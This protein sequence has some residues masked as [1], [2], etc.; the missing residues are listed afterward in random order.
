MQSI[1]VNAT[2]SVNATILVLFP[3]N[4]CKLTSGQMT[5]NSRINGV[6]GLRHGQASLSL[7]E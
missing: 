4:L 1:L 3:N 6:A 7:T 5:T 2:L